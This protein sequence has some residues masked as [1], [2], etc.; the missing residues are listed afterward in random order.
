MPELDFIVS[1]ENHTRVQMAE[2]LSEMLRSAGFFVNLRIL[3]RNEFD[4]AL[5]SGDFDCYYAEARAAPN[6][7]PREFLLPEGAFAYGVSEN[8]DIRAALDSMDPGAVWEAYQAHPPMMAVCF[9]NTLFISQRGLLSG[10][11]PTFFN[12]FANFT[13]WTVHER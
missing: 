5:Q 1:A 9:R 8:H 13:E 10:Q 6:F 2:T 4:A 7:D 11:A 12:P 3:G